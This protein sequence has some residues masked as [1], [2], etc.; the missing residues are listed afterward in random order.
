MYVKHAPFSSSYHQIFQYEMAFRL[1]NLEMNF[2]G[3]GIMKRLNENS[4]IVGIFPSTTTN[5]NHLFTSLSM[6]M[7][8]GH[9]NSKVV[10]SVVFRRQMNK[11]KLFL[12][13]LYGNEAV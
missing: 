6:D 10:R 2:I 11:D 8:V 13:F 1:R 12:T 3:T 9:V 5:L 7:H 4:V